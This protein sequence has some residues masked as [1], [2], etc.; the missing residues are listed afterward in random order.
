M[1]NKKAKIVDINSGP[2]WRWETSLY[3]VMVGL[4]KKD[5]EADAAAVNFILDCA[6]DEVMRQSKI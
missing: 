4:K 3:F 2:Y 5:E 6:K 1:K